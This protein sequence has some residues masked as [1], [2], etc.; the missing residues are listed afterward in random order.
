MDVQTIDLILTRLMLFI[1]DLLNLTF[2]IKKKP[3]IVDLLNL[4]SFFIKSPLNQ[5]SF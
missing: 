3:L 2:S 5:T 1:V 4:T